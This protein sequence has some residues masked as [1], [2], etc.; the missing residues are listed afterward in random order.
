MR[1]RALLPIESSSKRT[2]DGRGEKKEPSVCT[3][4]TVWSMIT[5]RHRR[6][7]LCLNPRAEELLEKEKASDVSKA[8][9]GLLEK[10]QE[11]V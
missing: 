5:R 1:A 3:R 7:C 8:P 9:E 11:S 6:R 10:K 2:E 4:I